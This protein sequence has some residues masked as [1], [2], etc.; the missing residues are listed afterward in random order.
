MSLN[1]VLQDSKL[2]KVDKIDNRDKVPEYSPG[3][4]QTTMHLFQ[5]RHAFY[6]RIPSSN[7]AIWQFDFCIPSIAA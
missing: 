7:L 5:K 2:E 4:G 6:S 3:R 1:Q